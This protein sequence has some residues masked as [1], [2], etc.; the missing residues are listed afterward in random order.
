MED[1]SSAAR[2]RPR[3]F[4]RDAVLDKAIRLFWQRGYEAT[5]VRNLTEELGI[6]PPSLYSA[7]GPKQDLFAEA[8]AVYDRE[9]GGFIDR[10]IAEEPTAKQAA[11]RMLREGPDRYTRPGLPTGCLVVSGDAGT[12]NTGVSTLLTAMRKRKVAELAAKIRADVESGA[13]PRDTDTLALSQYTMGALTGLAQAARD[14]VGRARLHPVAQ[15]AQTAW[16]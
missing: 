4:D 16:P 12:S 8:L 13:L 14:G 15:I 6:G 10:A 1:M 2:G 5:S 7:F 3:S 11:A 9:Y